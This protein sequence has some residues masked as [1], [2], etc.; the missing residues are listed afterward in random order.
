MVTTFHSYV[1]QCVSSMWVRPNGKCVR[2]SFRYRSIESVKEFRQSCFS[3][4][5]RMS[6]STPIQKLQQQVY[7][8][9]SY[10]IWFYINEYMYIFVMSVVHRLVSIRVRNVAFH[11]NSIFTL[12]CCAAPKNEN[13]R[14]KKKVNRARTEKM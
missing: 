4:F 7:S 11:F 3:S 6:F 2:K 5:I 13:S 9:A 14:V 1:D 8:C 10:F 12:L